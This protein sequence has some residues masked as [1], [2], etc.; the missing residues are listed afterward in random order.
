MRRPR[1]THRPP[2]APAPPRVRLNLFLARAAGG[3]RREAEGWVREDRV[4][5]NGAP[6]LGFGDPIDP[7]RDRV[8][9]DGR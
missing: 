9:L 2:S 1:T 5:I 8:T 3:S 6:P 7:A 4:R